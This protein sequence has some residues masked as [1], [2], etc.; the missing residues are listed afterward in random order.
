MFLALKRELSLDNEKAVSRSRVQTTGAHYNV[1]ILL[2]LSG[3]Q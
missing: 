2:A 3:F 1:Q